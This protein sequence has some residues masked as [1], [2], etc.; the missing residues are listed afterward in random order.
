MKESA[1]NPEPEIEKVSKE[2]IKKPGQNIK[3]ASTEIEKIGDRIVKVQ[4][5]EVVGKRKK[6]IT[7]VDVKQSELDKMLKNS[8]KPAQAQM[9]LF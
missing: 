1:S 5:I 4:F 3:K 6:K 2:E 9:L 7:H 8:D